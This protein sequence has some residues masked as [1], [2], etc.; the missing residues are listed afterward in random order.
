MIRKK[1][2]RRRRSR[3]AGGH[4]RRIRLKAWRPERIRTPVDT[5][6]SESRIE[7]LLTLDKSL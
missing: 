7:G 1:Q 2:E 3:P 5:T 4:P 6:W